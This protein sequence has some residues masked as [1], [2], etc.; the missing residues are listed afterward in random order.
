M[1]VEVTGDPKELTDMCRVLAMNGATFRF[2]PWIIVAETDSYAEANK[3]AANLSSYGL[4]TV[5][6]H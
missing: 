1:K 4:N 5:I 6:K 2:K 3:L